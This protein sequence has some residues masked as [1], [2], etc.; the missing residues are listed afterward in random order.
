MKRLTGFETER[1]K[2]GMLTTPAFFAIIAAISLAWSICFRQIT[3]NSQKEKGSFR[4]GQSPLALAFLLKL[5]DPNEL[6]VIPPLSSYALH[7]FS[8]SPVRLKPK[9]LKDYLQSKYGRDY[10]M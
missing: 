5:W 2:T 8:L 10:A 1:H 3:Q 9:C 7:Q 6:A 4:G